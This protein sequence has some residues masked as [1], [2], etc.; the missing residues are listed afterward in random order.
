MNK[1]LLG[2]AILAAASLGWS[3]CGDGQADSIP[4]NIV[5][6]DFQPIHSDF[7]NFDDRWQQISKAPLAG[8]GLF[9]PSCYG[10]T[11]PPPIEAQQANMACEGGF[12]CGAVN[13]FT[14][15]MPQQTY[16]GE[17]YIS[18]NSGP[19]VKG[20]RHV[21]SAQYPNSNKYWEDPVW[22]TR[23]MVQYELNQANPAD[24]LTW[25]PRKNVNL[26][27]NTF[28]DEHWFK[29]DATWNKT[30]QGT[31]WLKRVGCTKQYR[32]DSKDM[33]GGSY[34]PLDQSTESLPFVDGVN[35][36]GRQ[37]L[38]L[39]CPPYGAYPN[40]PLGEYAYPGGIAEAGSDGSLERNVC[41]DLLAN[42]G[43]RSYDAVSEAVAQNPGSEVM[44]HNYAF[45]MMGYNTFT[46][47]PTDTFLFSGDDDMWI[48]VDG[49]LV[50]DLGGTHL[51]AEAR[52]AMSDVAALIGGDWVKGSTHKLHFYYADR[53]TD[54]SNLMITTTIGK[55]ADPIFGAPK[56]RKAQR[57]ADG[58]ILIYLSNQLH[59]ESIAQIASGAVGSGYFPILVIKRVSDS[60]GNIIVD[61][62]GLAINS[63]KYNKKNDEG[64]F[65]Y[66]I[67]GGLY[68]TA[69]YAG[70]Q[71]VLS[72]G[73]SL[74]FN[75]SDPLEGHEFMVGH[76]ATNLKSTQNMT[77]KAFTWG[78]VEATSVGGTGVDIETN[79]TT[80]NRP[81]M[82]AAE[83]F[84]TGTTTTQAMTSSGSTITVSKV[85]G[86][87]GEEMP[88]TSMGEVSLSLLPANNLTAAQIDALQK[89]GFGAPPLR[90]GSWSGTY[91][92]DGLRT[93]K[94]TEGAFTYNQ[95]V[96]GPTSSTDGLLVSRCSATKGQEGYDNSCLAVNFVTDRAFTAN[97]IV[98]DH[99]GN[100]V[101]R[102]TVNVADST[103]RNLQ[104]TQSIP[105]AAACPSQDGKTNIAAVSTGKIMASINVYPFSQT[106]RKLGTGV[107]LLNVDI[108]QS[109]N[110]YCTPEDPANPAVT[111]L[112]SQ[113]FSRSFSQIKLAYRRQK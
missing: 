55:V 74:A 3:Q 50:A 28:F 6:R 20:H 87:V 32:I 52:V 36:Y 111:A 73:D 59:D 95:I 37:S 57:T 46:Y 71:Y 103:I 15:L 31:M 109:A 12:P 19:R 11:N 25:V 113:I 75:Y 45:T 38:K 14:G 97:V 7:E 4:F 110:Q 48:Y 49:K 9:T 10:K 22:V 1:R 107:Y 76:P 23:G 29:D 68:S 101:S 78:K 30:V 91:V 24:P 63:I 67:T 90:S 54:G 84:G 86:A 83:L 89:N 42:G 72:A 51:P 104:N 94:T 64:F 61:T 56:I 81:D 93:V 66:E 102:Y 41:E 58:S 69:D 99:M 96:Q 53:Q 79:N 27:H 80:I 39:W 85:P 35:T 60:S 2:F 106:G 21:V 82:D 43:P 16:Y 5:V 108:M 33:E 92:V 112:Q 100:Y 8:Y 105:G 70:L 13:P 34:F 44:L 65:V 18:G 88:N 17:Y 47:S 77:V 26:C 62:M 40:N 98:Y